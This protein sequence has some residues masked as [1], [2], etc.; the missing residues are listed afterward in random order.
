MFIEKANICTWMY[1]DSESE[2]SKY[3]QVPGLSSSP[4]FQSTYWRCVV[5]FFATSIFHNSEAAHT[6]FTNLS[7]LPKLED[8]DIET[9]LEELGVQVV[10]IPLT[11]QTPPAYFGAW[12]N[13]FY[14]FDMIEHISHNMT[15][16]KYHVILDSDCVWIKSAKALIT[17]IEKNGLLTYEI[18]Y[19]EDKVVNGLSRIEARQIYSELG[20]KLDKEVPKYFGG[21]FFAADI[22]SIQ[23]VVSVIPDVWRHSLKSFEKGEPK[24][25]E[26]AQALSY[27]YQKLGFLGGTANPYIRRIW[28]YRN[29]VNSDDNDLDLSI[30]HLPAEKRYG[31]KR[32][33]HEVINRES[34]FW[35]LK[36]TVSFRS[37]LSKQLGVPENSKEKLLKDYIEDKI[38]GFKS[39]FRFFRI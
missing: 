35:K 2:K 28:T 15:E 24:F 33:Y 5:V 31:L 10:S 26:E 23:K 3:A 16:Y 37:Y 9:L 6:L 22:E 21:E 1:S 32:L 29:F 12:R 18:D 20:T 7:E 39:R 36:D 27:I 38:S 8:F 19:P 14:L 13:Q 34:K 30:W 17:D 11:Y 4:S 25:N